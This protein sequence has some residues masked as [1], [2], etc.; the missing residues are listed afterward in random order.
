M[1]A[2]AE[3]FTQE[4]MPGRTFGEEDIFCRVKKK[5]LLK[6]NIVTFVKHLVRPHIELFSQTRYTR[7]M[8]NS[9]KILYAIGILISLSGCISKANDMVTISGKFEE[10]KDGY[11]LNGYVIVENEISKYNSQFIL[12]DYKDKEVEI[13]GKIREI[14]SGDCTNS[15]GEISQCRPGKTSYIYDIQSIK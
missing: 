7:L 11:Y 10:T 9:T 8:K 15:S 2:V 13:T 5:S 6:L 3:D 1:F 12:D 4:K 14:D